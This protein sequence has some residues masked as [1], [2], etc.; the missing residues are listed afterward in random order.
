[1]RHFLKF[2]NIIKILPLLLAARTKI[3]EKMEDKTIYRCTAC[4]VTFPPEYNGEPGIACAS[5]GG[6]AKTI[7]L[8]FHDAIGPI[9]EWFEVKSKSDK[10]PSKRKIRRHL[11]MGQEMS[12]KLGRHVDKVWDMDRDADRYFEHVVDPETGETIRHCDEPL[13]C[14]TGHGSDKPK[15]NDER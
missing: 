6:L 5:C 4:G 7:E 14:H 15:S 3:E 1:L 9:R 12:D 2:R 11:R 10:M 8:H 13:S